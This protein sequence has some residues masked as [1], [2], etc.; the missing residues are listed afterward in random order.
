[1]N[2]EYSSR[3]IETRCK[4]DINFMYLL[5]DNPAPD[6]STI[7]RFRS[8]HF[9]L[10]AEKLLAQM[11]EFLFEIGEI[12]GENIFV[13]G[14][15]IESC[16]NKYTFVWKKAVTKNLARLL[17]NIA[18]LVQSCEE[19]YGIK[20]IY[21]NEVH[22]KHVKRLRR[23]LYALKKQEKVVFVHGIGKHYQQLKNLG[24]DTQKHSKIFMKYTT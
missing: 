8:L 22:M 9:S 24:I 20:I 1:M 23:K 18:A 15:K 4:R 3:A 21:R 14:T 16:A 11:S 5:E 19:E 10:C 12:S 17:E 7:A 2:R 13:D 6:H